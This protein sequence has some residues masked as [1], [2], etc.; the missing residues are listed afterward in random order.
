MSARNS[1]LRPVCRFGQQ[2]SAHFLTKTLKHVPTEVSLHVLAYN[3][4]RLVSL[5]D[6]AQAMREM[7]FARA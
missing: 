6:I 2:H 7:R 1:Y 4:K 3:L 5:L